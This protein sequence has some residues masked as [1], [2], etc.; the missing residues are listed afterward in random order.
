MSVISIDLVLDNNIGLSAWHNAVFNY[1]RVSTLK[2]MFTFKTES[3]FKDR[4]N[5]SI[6]YREYQIIVTSWI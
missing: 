5:S 3:F 4:G 1:Q 2:H 6:S